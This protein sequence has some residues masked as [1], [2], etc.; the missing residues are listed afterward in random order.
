LNDEGAT[1]DLI[2]QF[3]ENKLTCAVK[4]TILIPKVTG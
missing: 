3:Y 4:G 2:N 1:V